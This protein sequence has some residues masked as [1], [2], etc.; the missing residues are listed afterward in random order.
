[1][2]YLTEASSIYN[3]TAERRYEYNQSRKWCW[4]SRRR[5]S[6]WHGDWRGLLTITIFCKKGWTQG[7]PCFCVWVSWLFVCVCI[8]LR[9]DF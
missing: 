8:N 3:F 6:H 4:Y 1:M 9:D 2:Y 7:E 5:R